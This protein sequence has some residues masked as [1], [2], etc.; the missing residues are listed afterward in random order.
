MRFEGKV[1][2]VTGGSLGIGAACTAGLAREGAHVV[3]ASLDTGAGDRLADSLT[4]AP[5]TAMHVT[6]DVAR[7]QEVAQLV[8]TTLSRHGGLDILVN[9]AG[10]YRQ[11]TAEQTTLDDW[12]AVIAVNLTG[13]FLCTKYAVPALRRTRGT[14][15]NIASEAGLVGIVGQ[16][17]YNTSKAGVI[18][19]TRSCAVDFAADGVRVNCVCPGTTWTPLVEAAVGRA[20]DPDSARRQLET[21]RPMDRL[22]TPDEI[23]AAVLF[24][25]GQEAGYATGASLSVDGGYTAQ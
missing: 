16:A 21:V 13:V 14:I 5:G 20:P 18:A 15:V 2:I 11:G 1:A 17:A 4:E 10:I 19:L 12:Q 22:G 7:E 6:A 9:N 8:E 24:L 23:A 3:M 25:A